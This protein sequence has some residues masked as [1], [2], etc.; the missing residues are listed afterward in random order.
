MNVIA[1]S[2]SMIAV[3]MVVVI[4]SARFVGALIDPAGRRRFFATDRTMPRQTTHPAQVSTFEH[5]MPHRARIERR[6]PPFQIVDRLRRGEVRL[7]QQQAVGE[8]GLLDGFGVLVDLPRAVD[9]I[10]CGHHGVKTHKMNHQGIVE[11]ELNDRSGIGEPGGL[12]QDPRK[13]RHFAAVSLDQQVAQRL[14]QVAAQRAADA[15]AGEHRDF[16]SI[17]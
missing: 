16:S 12:D 4:M 11:Q 10:D 17:A 3:S 13:G 5:R 7:G 6:E 2:G 14:F 9:R 8:R 1:V 15:A